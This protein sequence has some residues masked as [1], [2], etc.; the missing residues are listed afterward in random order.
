MFTKEKIQGCFWGLA[1][2][3]ALGRPVEFD[4]ID[5]IRERYGENGIQELNEWSIWSDDTEMTIAVTN[6]LLRLG[7]VDDIAKLVDEQIG[8]TFAEEFIRWYDNPGYAP[9]ITCKQ[10]VHFLIK[11]GAGSWSKSGNNDSKGSGTAMRA[12]PIGV[13]FA[14][15]LS[16]ELEDTNTKYFQLMVKISRTQSEIT[17]GHKAATAAAL[18]ASYAVVLAFNNKNPNEFIKLIQDFCKGIHPDFEAALDRSQIALL[19]RDSGEFTNDVDALHYIGQGWVGDEAVAMALY[20]FIREPN[21]IKKCL[22]IASNHNGD[23]DSVA[24]IAGSIIGA[25]RGIEKIPFDWINKLAEKKR[26]DKIL[27]EIFNFYQ[28]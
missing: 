19:K 16:S 7:K 2:G 12:A 18:A 6:A 27:D 4:H 20:A 25:L 24:C 14:K 15:A 3:D 26:I 9:G 17:H 28:I 23:S 10:A 5:V 21:D 13:W 1:L 8:R 11:N 22:R